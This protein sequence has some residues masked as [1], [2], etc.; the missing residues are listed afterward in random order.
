M[1]YLNKK[2]EEIIVE[3]GGIYRINGKVYEIVEVTRYKK[4]AL[5]LDENFQPYGRVI[6]I[7]VNKNTNL[8]KIK[9]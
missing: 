4:Y 6:T 2:T 8:E 3:E 1:N 5:R 9:L 7:S